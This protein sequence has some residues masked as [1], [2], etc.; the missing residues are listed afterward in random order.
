MKIKSATFIKSAVDPRSYPRNPVPEIAFVGRSNVGKSTLM[1]RLMNRQ[2]LAKV[3]ATPGKTQTIN[4]FL[5]NES[6][7]FVDLPGY[8]FANVPVKIKARWKEM[9][10]SYLSGRET[11]S[12]VLLLVDIRRKPLKEDLQM[13]QWLE[14]YGIPCLIIATKSDKLKTGEKFRSLSDLKNAYSPAEI[15][16]FSGLTGEGKDEIW[17]QIGRLLGAG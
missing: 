3:S 7:R 8:G 13:K 2:G 17:S 15:F 10:E 16:L 5:I 1:N 14:S 11:L 6:F 4:F 9:I 12:G